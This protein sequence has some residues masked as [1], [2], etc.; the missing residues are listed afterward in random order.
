MRILDCFE[1]ISYE[2]F[3]ILFSGFLLTLSIYHFLL[4]F[5]HKDR[6]YL[7]YSLYTF[8]IFTS[9]Y[10]ETESSFF[11]DATLNPNP[12]LHFLI[13]PREWIYNTMYLIFAKTLVEL[14]IFKPKIDK[15]VNIGVITLLIV[16][17][18]T[19]I[20][21]YITGRTT[22]VGTVYAYLFT[23]VIGILSLISLY[24]LYT[25]DTGL[26]YYVL[27]GSFIYLL[28]AEG[29]FYFTNDEQQ[30]TVI[31]YT[32]IIIEN[33]LFS[34]ALGYKQKMILQEKN[35]SQQKLIL[36]LQENEKLRLKVYD[37]L[38]KDV[39]LLNEQAKIN[40]LEKAKVKS[41]K[42]LLELKISSLQSQMNPHF[43]FNSLNAIKLY[44]IDNEKEN[45]VYYLNKFSKLI[46]K[47][48]A[49]AREKENT[50]AEE[51]ETL[52]LY[53][54]IENIR[55]HNEIESSFSIDKKLNL[56]TLKIPTLILQPFIENAIWHGLSSKKGSKK[57]TILFEKEAD[58]FLK[59]TIEDNGIGRKKSTEIK[60][61]K[62]H[63]KESIG[64]KLTE[65]RLSNFTKEFQLDYTLNYDDLYDE[66]NSASGTKVTLK[67]PLY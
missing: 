27:T 55:F 40:Q 32:G 21:A 46:R 50:L 29:A 48:L 31:F 36:Q 39:E 5:Q 23:S 12:Y 41:D 18:L 6:V 1:L 67:I 3:T 66:K 11:N 9:S 37:Q 33:I 44:I 47:I 54:E 14:N 56:N 16:L 13:I 4:Y 17:V 38:Q 62:M 52:K 65:E 24:A 25:M 10:P 61:N 22:L 63:R 43:I 53:F 19:M 57:I 34:L 35:D 60:N 51:I 8:L 2:D 15:F 64:I 26:K 42:E 58:S 59:I 30:A 7:Y 28:L 20:I 49:S 45:A